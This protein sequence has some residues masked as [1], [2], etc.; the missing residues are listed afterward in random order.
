MIGLTRQQK[1]ALDFIE[2][3]YDASGVPPS[4][5]ELMNHMGLHSKSGIHR[6]ILALEERG[7]IRRIPNRAR[8]IEPTRSLTP[9][10]TVSLRPE[11][12]KLLKKVSALSGLSPQTYVERMLFENLSTQMNSAN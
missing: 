8:A 11:T 4:Y 2:N 5:E 7:A 12:D 6:I 10:L 1:R 3:V 9:F